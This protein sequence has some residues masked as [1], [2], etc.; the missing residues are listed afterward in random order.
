MI[1]SLAR[2]ILIIF[3]SCTL[4][5]PGPRRLL[6]IRRSIASYTGCGEP[7]P[8]VLVGRTGETNTMQIGPRET[9]PLGS[10]LIACRE[11]P[12]VLNTNDELKRRGK[13]GPLRWAKDTAVGDWLGRPV[14]PGY[15]R[16]WYL[17]SLANGPIGDENG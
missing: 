4:P 3:R 6:L 17:D 14:R 7:N 12:A 15:A 5:V 16:Y 8:C 9:D 10:I 11:G 2:A 13:A 1:H